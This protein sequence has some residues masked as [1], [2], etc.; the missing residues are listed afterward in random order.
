M[1]L[2]PLPLLCHPAQPGP[3]VEALE[4]QAFLE[5]GALVLTFQLKGNLE[6]LRIPG[7]GPIRR[8]ERLW[9]GTCFEAFLR[10]AGG[11]AYV[12]LNLAP[13]AAWAAYAFDGTRRGMRDLGLAPDLRMKR[14][15]DLVALRARIPLADLPGCAEA[16]C[17]ELNL[18]AVVQGAEGTVSHWCLEP[19]GER[20]DFHAPEGFV[21]RLQGAGA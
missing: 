12:E 14:G 15:K 9:E 19:R 18:A 4:A 7:L 3:G 10:P 11:E 2:D 1:A 6:C 21:L 16:S 8:A 5:D 20:P 17:L 13:S